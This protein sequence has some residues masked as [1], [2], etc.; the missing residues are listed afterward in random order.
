[1]YFL[2]QA[3]VYLDPDHYKIFNALEELNV[4]YE[5]INILPTAEK[6]DFKTDRKDVFVYGS[7]TIARLAKQN[8]DWFP[9][10]FYGG[11]HLYEVYSRF[12]GKNLLNYKVSVHKVSEDLVWKN[13][14]KKF[15]KPYNEAKI[16]TGRVFTEI[17]WKDFIFEAL[18]SQ[19]NR[20]TK[21]SIV[22]VSEAKH[23]IKEARLWIIGGQ[24][25]DGGYYKF[26]DDVPFEE[27][28]SE[29]GLIFANE[30]I[31]LF[32]LEKAFVMDIC[33]TDKGWK[34]V[35]INCINSSGFYPN[36]N[37]KS[38]IKALNIYFSN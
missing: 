10:S 2:I 32:N 18:E 37:V 3:N 15:I 31:G 6:I 36:T 9:G 4:D 33:L 27:K 35:E 26:N 5:V 38:I 19:S 21:D 34:I 29:D 25:V 13:D 30:M 14:E 7:V 16:F 8:S 23:T 1:M 22:Q 17:E 24:I 20:I 12:Y 28:I 11:N